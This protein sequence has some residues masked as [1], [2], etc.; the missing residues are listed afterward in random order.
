MHRI[1]RG[2]RTGSE[3]TT[4]EEGEP[5]TFVVDKHFARHIESVLL[6]LR[7]YLSAQQ[8]EIVRSVLGSSIECDPV[9]R[10]L[11]EGAVRT[12]LASIKS[13]LDPNVPR[14]SGGDVTPSRDRVIKK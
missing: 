8:L 10:E 12:H 11:A 3:R 5:H 6:P 9:S 1:E 7:S 2:N 13:T 4:E 14:I